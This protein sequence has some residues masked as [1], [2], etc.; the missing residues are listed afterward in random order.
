MASLFSDIFTGRFRGTT[1]QI[2]IEDLSDEEDVGL[3]DEGSEGIAGGS[4]ILS[5]TGGNGIG[6][7][8]IASTGESVISGSSGKG[9][10]CGTRWS[11]FVEEVTSDNSDN[12]ECSRLLLGWGGREA[13]RFWRRRECRNA[14][15]FRVQCSV[16]SL[17]ECASMRDGDPQLS[18]WINSRVRRTILSGSLSLKEW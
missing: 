13:L 6:I 3:G 18:C 16:G 10:L 9:S 17:S 7:D 15:V 1:V 4:G 8:S 14:S 11:K 2:S 5:E 12:S